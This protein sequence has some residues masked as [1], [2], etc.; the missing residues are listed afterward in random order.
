MKK[1]CTKCLEEKDSNNFYIQ[2]DRKSGSSYCKKC[3]N[4]YCMDRWSA[5]KIEAINYKGEKC[6]DC[7][8]HKEHPS[9]YEF[10]HLDPSQK[11][12]NW[13]KLRQKSIKAIKLEL[14]KCVLLCANCHR[15]R[16][17]DN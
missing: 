1:I 15:K 6:V 2:N 14:D 17:W 13:Q 10:H 5:R 8:L 11:D 3:F 7:G 4:K 16:H 12:Y 9:V